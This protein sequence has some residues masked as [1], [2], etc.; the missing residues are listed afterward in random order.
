MTR[1]RALAALLLP[2][3]ALT[4]ACTAQSGGEEQAC[5]GVLL[6][7]PEDGASSFTVAQLMAQSAGMGMTRQEAETLL[8][9]E[10][11]SPGSRLEPGESRC[12][13]GRPD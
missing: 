10:G 3:C 9:L 1:V 13:D 11:I 12:L 7:A 5:G 2:A 4:A 8:Y 6:S